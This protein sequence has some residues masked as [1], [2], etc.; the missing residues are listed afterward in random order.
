MDGKTY[1]VKV[2]DSFSHQLSQWLTNFKI[3]SSNFGPST[4]LFAGKTSSKFI[5]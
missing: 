3:A 2:K 1:D 5:H 4:V